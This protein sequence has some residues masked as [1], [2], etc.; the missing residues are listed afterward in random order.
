MFFSSDLA[1]VDFVEPQGQ[2]IS[3]GMVAHM[4]ENSCD[5]QKVVDKG[6][7]TPSAVTEMV[8]EHGK[9]ILKPSIKMMIDNDKARP[10]YAII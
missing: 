10:L 7:L 8:E 9:L 6:T 4:F 1:I 5:I 2:F 3:P